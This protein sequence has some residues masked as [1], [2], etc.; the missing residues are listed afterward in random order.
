MRTL[1]TSVVAL[2]AFAFAPAASLADSSGQ[3][4][5]Q[6]TEATSAETGMEQ[7][8]EQMT[9]PEQ[10]ANS[11]QASNA[12]ENSDRDRDEMATED[13]TKDGKAQQP[14]Q[15]A[16]AEAFLEAQKRQQA[17]SETYLGAPVYL[18]GD[19]EQDSIG[20][21]DTLIFSENGELHG[22]VVDVGGFLG[23]GEKPVGVKWS[24]LT[25]ERQQETVVF[26]TS[27]SRA[28]FENA[29]EYRTL[30]DQQR[31]SMATEE[32]ETQNEGE[33]STY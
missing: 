21:I 17:L 10:D 4:Q 2:S 30:G 5:N 11:G 24:A 16:S 8:R 14:E 18:S 32:A 25:E 1:F 31:E 3:N 7:S 23:L 19:E 27:M 28:D 20:E 33:D 12:D 29:P 9:D 13:E 15:T 26:T 22:A 6:N